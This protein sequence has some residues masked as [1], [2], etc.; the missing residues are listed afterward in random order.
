M[1]HQTHQ[2]MQSGT[3]S[4]TVKLATKS[5]IERVRSGGQDKNARS[6]V[7][8]PTRPRDAKAQWFCSALQTSTR[9]RSSRLSVLALAELAQA[10]LASAINVWGCARASA[11]QATPETPME[12]VGLA[13]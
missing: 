2:R 5:A 13:G 10:R 6:A 4:Q 8:V 12:C 3:G 9:Q 11:Q 7:V 1:F